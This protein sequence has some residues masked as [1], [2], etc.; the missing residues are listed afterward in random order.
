MA[1]TD[2]SASAVAGGDWRELG[3]RVRLIREH[4]AFRGLTWDVLVAAAGATHRVEFPAG[5]VVA[6]RG[7][8]AD[9]FYIVESGW[10]RLRGADGADGSVD[11]GGSFGDA[12]LWRGEHD[13]TITAA[14]DVR[15]LAL[16]REAGS[17]RRHGV[18]AGGAGGGA[19]DGRQDLH[20]RVA[21]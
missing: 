6:R 7:E 19:V 4:P 3:N 20:R 15:L 13:K 9:S 12:A 17:S 5:S 21:G 2:P 16:A 14:T 1:A 8:R 11:P 10:V 18:P